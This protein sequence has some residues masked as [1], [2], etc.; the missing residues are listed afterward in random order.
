MHCKTVIINIVTTTG[1]L[2]ILTNFLKTLNSLHDEII[3]F[4]ER[5]RYYFKKSRNDKAM[6]KVEGIDPNQ[7]EEPLE[8]INYFS[9]KPKTFLEVLANRKN[10]IKKQLEKD[11]ISYKKF[12]D[13]K[14]SSNILN[15]NYKNSKGEIDQKVSDAEIKTTLG[16]IQHFK[17]KKITKDIEDVLNIYNTFKNYIFT[18]EKIL[19]EDIN[20]D[21]YELTNGTKN[22]LNDIINSIK[23]HQISYNIFEFIGNKGEGKTITIYAWANE[24]IHYQNKNLKS[25]KENKI[26][27]IIFDVEDIL[28]LF[29]ESKNFSFT[30]YL[31]LKFMYQFFKYHTKENSIFKIIYEEVFL[32]NSS[33]WEKKHETFPDKDTFTTDQIFRGISGNDQ[34][35]IIRHGIAEYIAIIKEKINTVEKNGSYRH[36][37][38]DDVLN[39]NTQLGKITKTWERFYSYIQEHLNKK[40]TILNIIDGLDNIEISH[41]HQ[42]IIEN[43]VQHI[44]PQ[45]DNYYM[46]AL[47][48]ETRVYIN[49]YINNKCKAGKSEDVKSR[50]EINSRRS[51]IKYHSPEPKILKEKRFKDFATKN[52]IL[53]KQLNKSENYSIGKLYWEILKKTFSISLTNILINIFN[54]VQLSINQKNTNEVL[55]HYNTRKL[56]R[57]KMSLSNHIFFRFVQINELKFDSNSFDK[58]YDIIAKQTIKPTLFLENDLYLDNSNKNPF[59]YENENQTKWYGLYKIRILQLLNKTD[60]KEDYII[61]ALSTIF[62]YPEDLIKKGYQSLLKDR[63]ITSWISNSGKSI[64]YKITSKGKL[65]FDLIFADDIDILYYFSLDTDVPSNLGMSAK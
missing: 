6:K 10:Y 61:K 19:R 40:Y 59:F 43:M 44:Y 31:H 7:S 51:K 41:S 50:G 57:Y 64:L 34:Q 48:P 65:L 42:E 23:D 25:L 39:R 29:R 46:I 24:K 27:T 53:T 15:V 63:Y 14:N 37:L 54:D 9:K 26:F 28:P 38:L 58:N 36:Y 4:I 45:K 32:E 11:N 22:N 52:N 16:L 13:L 56:V 17:L 33:Y 47:R 35:T 62:G 5:I 55:F 60:H 12:V 21:Y 18:K 20:F 1:V 2:W 30:I 3:S 49:H 8:K